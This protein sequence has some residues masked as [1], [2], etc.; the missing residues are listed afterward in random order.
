MDTPFSLVDAC[1]YAQLVDLKDHYMALKPEA[2]G[3]GG[4]IIAD[5]SYEQLWKDMR[6]C[7]DR[8][9]KDGVIK[10]TVANEPSKYIQYDP[11][12]F[13]MLQAFKKA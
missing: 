6:S 1:L 12:L 5:K 4:A 10:K 9:H 7:V 2:R 13:P 11:N 3:A 8:C